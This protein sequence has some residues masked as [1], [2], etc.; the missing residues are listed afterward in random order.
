M[1]FLIISISTSSL[2]FNDLRVLI[3]SI[4]FLIFF[5]FKLFIKSPFKIPA[6]SAGLPFSTSFITADVKNSFDL[7][8][9]TIIPNEIS[10]LALTDDVRKKFAKA[11]KI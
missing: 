2:F 1:L 7:S 6:L 10:S 9:P 4:G 3:N 11:I 8:L 5:L